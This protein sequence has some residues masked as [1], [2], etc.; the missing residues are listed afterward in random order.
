MVWWKSG[1]LEECKLTAVDSTGPCEPGVEVSKIITLVQL[2]SPRPQAT[3]GWPSGPPSAVR[4]MSPHLGRRPRTPH[5]VD[6]RPQ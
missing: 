1:E 4:A 6:G 2:I 5:M 3:D